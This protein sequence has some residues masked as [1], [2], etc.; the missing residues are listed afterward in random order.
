MQSTLTPELLIDE[1][2]KCIQDFYLD[3]SK[4]SEDGT[5]DGTEVS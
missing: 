3:K 4:N 5:L 2:L 1:P